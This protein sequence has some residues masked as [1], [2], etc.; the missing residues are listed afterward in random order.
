MSISFSTI[1]LPAEPVLPDGVEE[2][3]LSDSEDEAYLEEEDSDDDNEDYPGM[4][5]R[6]VLTSIRLRY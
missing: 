2:D 3:E 6:F 5:W 4:C 1:H